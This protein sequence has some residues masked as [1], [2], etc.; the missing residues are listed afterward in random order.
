MVLE[1]D[2]VVA[3]EDRLD[4]DALGQLDVADR[5]RDEPVRGRH[6]RRRLGGEALDVGV[7]QAAEAVW[8]PNEKVA[9]AWTEYVQ[10]GNVDD[11]T[12][13]PSPSQL[14]VI[15]KGNEGVE[16]TWEAE[17]DFESGLR[18]FLIQRDG[19][20]LVQLPEKPLGRFGRPLFQG[21]S[22]HDTPDPAL[23][24]LRFLDKTAQP[25]TSHQY[26]VF[27]INSVGLKSR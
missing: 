18:G 14:K 16:I 6:V 15:A 8:L 23:P 1:V 22:Y 11:N 26:R 2:R 13:P 4:L 20:D 17:A 25:G 19:K 7:G 9:Q 24:P 5:E 3:V 27:A 12:P 21:L 10:K